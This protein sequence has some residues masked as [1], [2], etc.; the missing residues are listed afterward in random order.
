MDK[1]QNEKG[2]LIY[3]SSSTLITQDIYA[4]INSEYMLK[5]LST[6]SKFDGSIAA[7]GFGD[8]SK[9]KLLPFSGTI[10]N[11]QENQDIEKY[12]YASCFSYAQAVLKKRVKRL[13]L[14]ADIALLSN[15]LT[16]EFISEVNTK[17]PDALIAKY[18]THVLTDITIGGTYKAI[19]RSSIVEE[20]NYTMKKKIVTSGLNVGLGKIGIDLNGTS[21]T[22]E[23]ITLNKKNAN[24]HMTVYCEAGEGTGTT[25]TF[26]SNQENPTTTVN[27]HNWAASVNQ[28]NAKLIDINWNKAFPIY[29]FIKDPSKKA[30]VKAAV[31][32]YA[33]NSQLDI[34]SIIPM[35]VIYDSSDLTHKTTTGTLSDNFGNRY[36]RFVGIAGYC[37][38][39]REST[40]IPLFEYLLKDRP[41][42]IITTEDYW[43]S[44]VAQRY[45][46]GYVYPYPYPGTVPLYEYMGN[47]P[48]KKYGDHV[49]TAYQDVVQNYAAGKYHA[50]WNVGYVFPRFP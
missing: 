34:L 19:Y 30:A 27:L 40:T 48:G 49:T 7:N 1:F 13:Y 33:E 9:G 2:H 24:W 16:A 5:E 47:P 10:K 32:K 6:N 31:T 29:E 45:I 14:D 44:N 18:G 35:Y 26:N 28:N 42:H 43:S 23:T 12:K 37:F 38:P 8:S 11:G 36:N 4:G 22:T 39:Y 46:I 50:D 41:G 20:E 21:S 17:S 25:I 15:Y 3:T